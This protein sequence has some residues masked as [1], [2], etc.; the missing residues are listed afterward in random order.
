MQK[1]QS[2]LYP[3]RVTIIAD[4]AGFTTEYTNV[5]Q[6]TI[7]IYQGVDNVIQFDV[8]NADQ[9]RLD[10]TT[11]VGAQ[12]LSLAVLDEGNKIVNTYAITP[13]NQTTYKGLGTVTIPATDL[14]SLYVPQNLKY[15][16]INT[17]GGVKTPLYTDSRFSALGTMELVASAVAVT[18]P[19]RTYKDFTA[20]IDLQ[21][22]PI[23][24]SSSIPVVFYEAVP[25]A[26]V[27][28]AISVKNFIGNVWLDATEQ[29][30]IAVESYRAAGRPF[31]S[32]ST[33]T[34]YT[35]VIPFAS[36]ITVGKYK[37]LRVSYQSQNSQGTGAVFSISKSGGTYTITGIVKGGTGY[38]AK[39]LILVPGS[40]LGGADGVNDALITVTSIATVG[41]SYSISSVTS[42]EISGTATAGSGAFQLSGTNYSGL[43][44]SIVVS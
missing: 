26:T 33:S 11:T 36:N 14:A 29:G 27:S 30:T 9:K 4:L 32:W 8:K 34:L 44:D 13:L 5:Y 18:R 3:N 12:T 17:T 28:L 20:E 22:L 2:Y 43:I 24:H 7:K 41:S 23:Y 35:G 15:S 10:L 25:T 6:R 1:I 19:S 16:V 38:T 42:A 37:Y 40:Q 39:A 21:G 31:G